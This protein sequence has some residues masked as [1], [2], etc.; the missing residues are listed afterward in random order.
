[1]VYFW[2][3]AI[4]EPNPG[5]GII[6]GYWVETST[7]TVGRVFDDELLEVPFDTLSDQLTVA[8]LGNMPV[9]S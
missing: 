6:K 7:C 8:V 9:F 2:P 4:E 1:M 3:M 5:S